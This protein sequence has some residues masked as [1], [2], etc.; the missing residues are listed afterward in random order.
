[1]FINSLGVSITEE[2][3]MKAKFMPKTYLGKLS[4]K[5][6]IAFFLFFGIAILL[7]T[8]GQVGG[9]SIFDNLPLGILM[10]ATGVSVIGSFITGL[11]SI[12]K[13]KERTIS[14]Y[15]ITGIGFYVCFFLIGELLSIIG[16]LPSH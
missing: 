1:M 4:G 2:E 10:L 5:F 6:M 11:M 15:I 9:D 8:F 16:I 3:Y 7:I 13:N 14:V 12:I